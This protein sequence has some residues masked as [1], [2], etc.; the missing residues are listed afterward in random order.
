LS[1]AIAAYIALG[2]ALPEACQQAKDLLHSS[3]TRNVD[4]GFIAPGPSFF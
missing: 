3:L 4:K 2:K 1:S